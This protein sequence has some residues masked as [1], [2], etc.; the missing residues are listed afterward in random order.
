MPEWRYAGIEGEVKWPLNRSVPPGETWFEV[1]KPERNGIMVIIMT[2]YWWKVVSDGD[3][4]TRGGYLSAR[5]DFAWLLTHLVICD[6]PVST[7][8]PSRKRNNNEVIDEPSPI[9]DSTRPT[10]KH[11]PNEKA[12]EPGPSSSVP[13]KT[14]KRVHREVSTETTS[15]AVARPCRFMQK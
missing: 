9:P 3:S 8:R 6:T 5:K 7:T 1:R 13:S 11:K 4:N 15:V 12:N 2:L 14:R 10:R